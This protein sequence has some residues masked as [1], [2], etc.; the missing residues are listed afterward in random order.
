MT[1]PTSSTHEY[2]VIVTLP[3]SGSISTIAICVPSGNVKLDGLNT[4][5]ASKPS[6]TS[7]GTLRGQYASSATSVNLT[8]F[9]G[10][11][12]T[13]YLPPSKTTS[14]SAASSM[15]DASFLPFSIT[16]CVAMYTAAPPTG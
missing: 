8:D 5:V 13:E 2:R 3:V 9:D 4:A 15:C 1:L 14:A 6:S 11:P 16:R 10:T 7:A 12:L